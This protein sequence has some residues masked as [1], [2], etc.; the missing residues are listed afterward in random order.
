[1]G[2]HNIMEYYGDNIEE[3]G[4][5][6]CVCVSAVGGWGAKGEEWPPGTGDINA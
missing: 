1:M 6:A 5:G 3:V 4:A 2:H